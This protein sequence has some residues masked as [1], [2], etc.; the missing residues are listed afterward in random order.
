MVGSNNILKI[1]SATV[2]VEAPMHCSIELL[3]GRDIHH[4]KNFF[5]NL[6]DNESN[7]SYKKNYER[8]RALLCYAYSFWGELIKVSNEKGSVAFTFQFDSLDRLEPFEKDL[9]ESVESAIRL[10]HNLT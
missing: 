1:T 2:T 3:T 9:Q 7:I 6:R 10:H 5:I 8:C 4:W